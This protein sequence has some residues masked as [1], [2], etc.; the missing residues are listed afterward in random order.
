M[1]RIARILRTSMVQLARLGIS[2]AGR[3][4]K[5]DALLSY[6]ASEEFAATFGG[7]REAIEKAQRALGK[8]RRHHDQSW[9]Q[10]EGYYRHVDSGLAAIYASVVGIID[11]GVA[12]ESSVEIQKVVELSTAPA[13]H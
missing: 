8:E 6:L 10:R 9:A 3:R 13:I 7:V 12:G 2:A 4:D 11:N 5:S 1:V